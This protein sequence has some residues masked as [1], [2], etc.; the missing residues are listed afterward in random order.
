MERASAM[1]PAIP[2]SSTTRGGTLAPRTPITRPKL[3][4][5]P[6]LNPYTAFRRK[7]PEA[8][9][10]QGSPSVPR[11]SPRRPACSAD[12]RARAR[13]RPVGGDV[14][15]RL[16]EELRPPGG[17]LVLHLRERPERA[18]PLGIPLHL[19]DGPVK[20][21]RIRLV[22]PV[23]APR[24]HLGLAF[25]GPRHGLSP[26]PT[27]HATAVAVSE[28]G[29]GTAGE[30]VGARGLEPRTFCSQ[31]RRAPRL[32]HAPAGSDAIMGPGGRQTTSASPLSRRTRKC[33]PPRG[34]LSPQ[35]THAS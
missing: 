8:I 24:P 10:C 22:L 34:T 21:R 17:V 25:R 31:S 33:P 30:M 3:A 23:L 26:C 28:P 7:P 9:L 19:G 12:S 29:N 20:V 6:S 4:V 14:H 16:P 15:P 5:R 13:A 18:R 2:D 35:G 27:A 32:R 11:S 1:R